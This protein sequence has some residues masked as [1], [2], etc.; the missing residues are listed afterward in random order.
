MSGAAL[1]AEL[2]RCARVRAVGAV[3]W[4]EGE[5]RRLFFF[6][7]GDLVLVQ[8]NVKADALDAVAARHPGLAPDEL[9]ARAIEARL[10]NALAE[11]GGDVVFH[12]G[13]KPPQRA[14]VDLAA[15]AWAAVERLPPLPDRGWPV[16]EPDGLRVLDGLPTSPAVLDYLRDLDGTRDLADVLD[17]G[18]DDPA[19]VARALRVACAL[20][21]ASIPGEEG[22]GATVVAGGA[23][24]EV[25][26]GRP[27][28][29]GGSAE[30][31]FQRPAPRSFSTGGD[32][33]SLISGELGDAA[34]PPAAASDPMVARL[35]PVVER[36]RAATDH[37]AVLGMTWEDPPD[38]LRRAYFQIARD[39]HPD[40]F[41][42]EPAD[43]VDA[44]SA[45][46]DRVREAWSV[47]G[48]DQKREAYIARTVR[49]ELSEEEQAM[50]KVRAILDAEADFRHALAD[51]RGGRLLQAHEGFLK[52][53]AAVPDELEFVGHAAFTT[54]RIESK[55]DPLAGEDAFKR[56]QAAA[57]QS[58][59][60]DSLYVLLG[61]ALRE[62]GRPDAAR[63][64]LVTALK[65]KPANPDA[66]RE[67]KRLERARDDAP[68]PTSEK[69]SFFGR[70]F[71]KKG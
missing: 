26:F 2:G 8:S 10:A 12:P 36:I 37:F 66:A 23:S 11:P 50:E 16:T 71:G 30:V 27:P 40:R 33:A 48:D 47:V 18:P 20:G 46:F 31:A 45:L 5:G 56:L 21:A 52:A 25:S 41:V 32:I 15:L 6:D 13:Q 38:A 9:R 3:E 54:W 53:A 58:G 17:F 65:L 29:R 63:R 57:E 62:S 34:P 70:L 55:R 19:V 44:A 39:L 60:L 51:F 14:P 1:L 61:V 49:G 4:R 35:G 69:P 59:K 7:G 68:P 28:E 24:A 43:V 67:L 64:A 22:H 42:G